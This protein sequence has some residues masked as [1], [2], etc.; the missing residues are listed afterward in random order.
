[1]PVWYMDS[2]VTYSEALKW[3]EVSGH[4]ADPKK[5]MSLRVVIHNSSNEIYLHGKD[6]KLIQFL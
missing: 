2:S 6:K 4:L 1:M 3:M 5:K